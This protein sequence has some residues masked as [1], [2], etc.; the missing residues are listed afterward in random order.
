VKCHAASI[1]AKPITIKYGLGLLNHDDI[2]YIVND[3]LDISVWLIPVSPE[4][5][6]G[7]FN[8][9]IA[10]QYCEVFQGCAPC[11]RPCRQG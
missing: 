10:A 5:W 6:F 9:P 1:Q 3:I 8:P 4:V 2:R 7:H 11:L